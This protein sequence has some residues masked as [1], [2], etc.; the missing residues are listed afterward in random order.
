[1]LDRHRS[2]AGVASDVCNGASTSGVSEE[3]LNGRVSED[4][5]L[6]RDVLEERYP[7]SVDGSD[8]LVRVTFI[9][10]SAGVTNSIA[11]TSKKSNKLRARPLCMR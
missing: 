3:S 11:V 8:G 1:M 7:A 10:S 6:P 2:I 9:H 4:G 5:K